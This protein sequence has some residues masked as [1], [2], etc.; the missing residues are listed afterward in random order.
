MD[1]APNPQAA[2]QDRIGYRFT[3]QHLLEGALTHPSA[4][5]VKAA[6]DLGAGYERLEFLGD[7]VLGLVIA[8]LLLERFPEEVTSKMTLVHVGI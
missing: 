1:D 8:E 6:A 2:L 5:I 4:G 7:R 3:N